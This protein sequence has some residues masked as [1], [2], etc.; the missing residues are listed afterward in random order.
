MVVRFGLDGAA[1]DA[2]FLG[3]CVCGWLR[4]LLSFCFVSYGWS[5]E[6]FNNLSLLSLIFWGLFS[7]FSFCEAWAWGLLYCL[8]GWLLFFLVG[9]VLQAY[10]GDFESSLYVYESMVWY[11]YGTI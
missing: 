10:S 7:F 9:G 11:S 8:L 6:V 4:L 5:Y 3:F 1:V 2:V